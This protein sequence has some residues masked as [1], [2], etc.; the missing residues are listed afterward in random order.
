[1]AVVSR[2]DCWIKRPRQ[3]IGQQGGEPQALA[4]G[5]FRRLWPPNKR[6]LGTLGAL[7]ASPS[8]TPTQAPNAPELTVRLIQGFP[9]GDHLGGG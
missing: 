3:L 2:R 6:L 8:L 9:V 7:A 1:M 5:P 4:V